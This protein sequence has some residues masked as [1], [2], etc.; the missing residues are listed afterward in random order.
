MPGR[1]HRYT[2]NVPVRAVVIG[3]QIR[4]CRIQGYGQIKPIKHTQ[5]ES[6]VSIVDKAAPATENLIFT[7][8]VTS[9]IKLKETN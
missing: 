4:L 2:A 1:Q 7:E 9:N 3:M 8:A 5:R 6:S